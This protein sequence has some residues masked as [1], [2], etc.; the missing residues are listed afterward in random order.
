M[1][2]EVAGSG[3]GYPK[4]SYDCSSIPLSLFDCS[5]FF[6]RTD[7]PISRRIVRAFLDFLD[8]VE[9]ASG[10]DLEGL[11]VAKDCLTE[12]FRLDRYSGDD[13][14][15]PNLLVNKFA[16]EGVSTQ[17]ELKAGHS[18]EGAAVSAQNSAENDLS[19]TSNFQVN[20]RTADGYDPGVFKDELFGQFFAALEKIHFFRMTPDGDDDHVLLDRATFLF[21]SALNEME[22][23]G[24]QTFDQ[25]SLATALK[26]LGNKAMQSL[27]Y[28]DAIELYTCAIALCENNA[29]YYCNRAAAYTQ[30]HKYNEA[31]RDCLKAIEIDP[32]YSKAYSRL[33]L[34]YYA[35]RNYSDAINKGFKKALELDPTNNAVKENI[36]VAEQKLKEELDRSRQNLNRDSS[37]HNN[38][39]SRNHST[40]GSANR[41]PPLPFASPPFFDA[42]AIP[43]DLT[44]MFV[45]MA[46]DTYPGQNSQT[47]DAEDSHGSSMPPPFTPP[48][49]NATTLPADL[50]SM[51]MNMSGNASWQQNFQDPPA[52]GGNTSGFDGPGI[53]IGGNVSVNIGE[54]MPE[55]L[56]GTLRSIMGMFSG[57]PPGDSQGDSNGRSASN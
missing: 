39:E 38:W 37:G 53:S 32:N 20:D 9:L 16:A 42:T 40:G 6:M 24:C 28:S 43:P 5:F 27:L 3:S 50:A 55:E 56:M 26:T 2:L 34:A 4:R 51:F 25:T 13:L 57:V 10:V 14:P 31:I 21:H 44:S 46:A 23:S 49:F 1:P 45:N 8:S 19:K 54:Q 29:V 15:E 22:T 12:V 11:E 48:P 52:E 36:R 7:D 17:N 35:Q 30:S 47:R 33:G 41:A 18:E